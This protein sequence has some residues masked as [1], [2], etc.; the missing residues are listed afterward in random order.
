MSETK[1]LPRIRSFEAALPIALL[2]AR[3]ATA[4]KFK[5]HTDAQDLSLPQWRVLRA[6]A[7]GEALDS[8]TIAYRC[9]LL[10]PS[11]SRIVRSLQDRGL[12][13]P[14]DAPDYRTRPLQLTEAG[15]AVFA[16][17]AVLSEATYLDIEKAF[18]RERLANLLSELGALTG[19]CESLPALPLPETLAT[20]TE[21]DR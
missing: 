19:I 14:G 7:G 18:G 6:L 9:A 15:Q 4:S 10:P 11:V 8:R 3:A 1:A 2:R 5:P 12:I 16:K 20:L 21:N 17:V 13:A